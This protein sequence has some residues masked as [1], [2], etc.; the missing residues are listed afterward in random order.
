MS[1]IDPGMTP[2]PRTRS[3]SSEPVENRGKSSVAI[4]AMGRGGSASMPPVIPLRSSVGGAA[5]SSA[6]VFHAPQPGHF[7]IHFGVPYPQD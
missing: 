2:P 3:S 6:M 7:P 4:A 1:T 5:I